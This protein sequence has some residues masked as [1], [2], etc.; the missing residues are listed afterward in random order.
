MDVLE[1]FTVLLNDSSCTHLCGWLRLG[2]TSPKV[3]GSIPDCVF[4]IFH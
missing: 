3:T 4:G 1:V 2:A